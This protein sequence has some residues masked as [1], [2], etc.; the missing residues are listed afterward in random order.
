MGEAVTATI[1]QQYS[2][3]LCHKLGVGQTNYR[4]DR[5]TLPYDRNMDIPEAKQRVCNE[6]D[7]LAPLLIDVSHQI[8]ARPELCFEEHFAHDLLTD[9]IADQGLAVQRRAYGLDTAFEAHAGRDDRAA[10]AVICEYD[11]LPGIGHACG[12]NI[13]AAAGL[14]AG[15]A[16]ASIAEEIGERVAVVGTP[17]EE[18][19]GGKE[20][21][22][23]NGAFSDTSA[24]MM[25]H[26]ANHE[27]STFHAV[28]VHRLTARYQGQAAHAAAAPEQGR[29]ALDAAVLGYNAVAALRQHI[30]DDERIHGI[31]TDSGT[32]PNIVPATA[33]AEWYVRSKNLSTLEPLKERVVACLKAGADAAVCDVEIEWVDPPYADMNDNPSLLNSY[34]ANLGAVGRTPSDDTGTRIVGSTD[35]GNVSYATPAIHPMIKVAPADV[36]IHTPAFA[37]H[38]GSCTGDAAVIDGAKAMAMTVVDCWLDAAVMSAARAAFATT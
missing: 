1:S 12:H 32:K 3:C 36:P 13:I 2:V 25:V 6:V 38:A 19:G 11:A 9:I 23:R 17:A 7:R 10:V 20:L 8:H 4:D 31:F 15:L 21:M 16:A 5:A 18:G 27:L 28:A 29:N 33:A 24:A 37:E 14:G 22:L 34:L 35:M 26:P 30:R